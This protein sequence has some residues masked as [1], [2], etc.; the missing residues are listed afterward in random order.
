MRKMKYLILKVSEAN[1]LIL[2]PD[3][4]SLLITRYSAL[5]WLFAVRYSL[6]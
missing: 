3:E 2:N 6:N 4:L 1:N 5:L